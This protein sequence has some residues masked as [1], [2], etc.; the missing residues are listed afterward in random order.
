MG[1]VQGE[2]MVCPRCVHRWLITT[3][4]GETI[5]RHCGFRGESRL[6]YRVAVFD[7]ESPPP[8]VVGE[9]KAVGG[10]QLKVKEE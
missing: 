8:G 3:Q 10:V 7:P 6:F 9:V 4:G 5:C 2:I 1:E